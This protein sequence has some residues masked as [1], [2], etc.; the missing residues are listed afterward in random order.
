[1]SQGRPVPPLHLTDEE[2]TELERWTRRAKMSQALA[3]RA[4]VILGCAAE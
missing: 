4:R 1:M 2:R 3:L